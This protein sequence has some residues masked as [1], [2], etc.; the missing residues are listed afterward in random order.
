VKLG[1]SEESVL[2]QLGQP[3]ARISATPYSEWVYSEQDQAEFSQQ[4]ESTLRGTFALFE[5]DVNGTLRHIGGQLASAPGEI[6]TGNRQN[7]LRLSS[8]DIRGLL[9][10]TMDMIRARFGEPKAVYHYRA[11]VILQYTKSA[12]GGSYRKREIGI[13]S[14]GRVAHIWSEFYED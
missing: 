11:V 7:Y 10:S 9:G 14:Q 13:D 4:G 6:V 5:F 3:L 12:T 1:D 2:Q 8:S